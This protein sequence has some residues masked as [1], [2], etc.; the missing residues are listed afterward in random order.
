MQTDAVSNSRAGDLLYLLELARTGRVVEAARRMGVRHTTVARRVSALE[1]ST[2]RRLVHRTPRGWVLTDDGEELLKYAES[3]E[4]TLHLVEELD[5]DGTAHGIGGTVRIAAQDGIG[6]TVVADAIVELR[7]AHP[8]LEIELATA[9]R[10]FDISS[11]DYDVSV[12]LQEPR[13]S[14]FV[15]DRLTDYRLGLYATPE[16][17]DQHPSIDRREDLAQHTIAW[18]IE[19]L[20]DLPELESFE[21]NIFPRRPALRSSNIFAQLRFVKSHGGV[22]LLPQYLIVD[23]P[24]VLT[25]VL[26]D[27]V[28]VVRT[29][30]MV[31]RKDTL[32]S[33]RVRAVV[34]HLTRHVEAARDQFL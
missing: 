26:P 22:G 32:N 17:L 2:G 6:A 9:T 31:T 3:I 12:T 7:L 34:D 15:V 24:A 4:A 13:M 30:W 28:S 25:P 10:R 5:R 19:S 29:F 8:R 23:D 27:D 14:Q 20:L 16:Y 11:R 18:Y 1:K 21:T 33:A